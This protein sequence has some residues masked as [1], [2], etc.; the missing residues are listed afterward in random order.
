LP[1]VLSTLCIVYTSSAEDQIGD[2]AKG[3]DI[4]AVSS[5]VHN[6]YRRTMLPNGKFAPES[7]I[8]SKGEFWFGEIA[9][10]T[11]ESVSFPVI[12]RQMAGALA[13]QNYLPASDPISAKLLIVINWGTTAA[14]EH[15]EMSRARA[16]LEDMQGAASAGEQSVKN[17]QADPKHPK[18]ANIDLK[19]AQNDLEGANLMVKAENYM[20]DNIIQRN[21]MLLGY[22]S[23]W[24]PDLRRYRYFV[25][26]LAY[27]FEALSKRKETKLLWETRFSISEHRNQFDKRLE[28]MASVAAGYFGEDTRGIV[29]R[30]VPTG[31]VIIGEVRSLETVTVSDL[32]DLAPDGVHVA[33]L[34]SDRATPGLEIVDVDNPGHFTFTKYPGLD[35]AVGIRWTDSK[36]LVV[37]LPSAQSVGFD[38]EGTLAGVSGLGTDAAQSSLPASI[39]ADIHSRA[40]EKFPHR[41]VSIIEGDKRLSRFLLAVSS[42]QG[43]ARLYVFDLNEDLLFD[44]GRVTATP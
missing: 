8:L 27:D 15:L 21:A 32:A 29:H 33:Y 35:S 4:E 5:A 17:A 43:P 23:A 13:Q 7:Y 39:R 44:V 6:G 28:A 31:R 40:E 16:Q 22:S 36:N 9:D 14:P 37:S 10:P 30:D 1:L 20:W 11:I 24:D 41:T 19:A 12:A 26:L 25:V 42:G 38:V 34:G 3:E 18:E 2:A